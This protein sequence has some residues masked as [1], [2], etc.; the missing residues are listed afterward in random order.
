M[1]GNR[2]GAEQAGRTVRTSSKSLRVKEKREKSV[3]TV[4]QSKASLGE[5]F[6]QN[7]QTK[8]FSVSQEPACL[9]PQIWG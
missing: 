1:K 3:F 2:L 8:E 5:S 6:S 4:V 7:P 9:N